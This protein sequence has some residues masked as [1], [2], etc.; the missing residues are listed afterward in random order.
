ML[1]DKE[2]TIEELKAKKKTV[3]TLM[4]VLSSLILMY[5]VYFIVKLVSGTWQSN[6]TLGI[7]GLCVLVVF[8]SNLTI[9]LSAI[10]KEVKSRLNKD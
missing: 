10:E 9:R 1:N 8:L 6:N 3:I 5:M 7:V 2:L 4:V